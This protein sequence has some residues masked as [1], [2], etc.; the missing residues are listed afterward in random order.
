MGSEGA[1]VEPLQQWAI[2]CDNWAGSAAPSGRLAVLACTAAAGVALFERAL[3]TPAHGALRTRQEENRALLGAIRQRLS[4]LAVQTQKH[5]NTSSQ[6]VKVDVASYRDVRRLL[7][8]CIQAMT[9]GPEVWENSDSAAW[10]DV[11]V[12]WRLQASVMEAALA[13]AQR[14][15]AALPESF[16]QSEQA[17]LTVQGRQARELHRLAAGEMSWRGE[18]S[19]VDT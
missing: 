14:G 2:A 18:G 11:E 17:T 13:L 15:L 6:G 5:G 12:G 7:D 1:S 16:Q 4:S 19:R 8:L 10:A 3:C 9:V